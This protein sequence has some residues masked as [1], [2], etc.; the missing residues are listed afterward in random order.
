MEGG[1]AAVQTSLGNTKLKEARKYHV[2]Q[3]WTVQ[4]WT[5]PQRRSTGAGGI[6]AKT[7]QKQKLAVCMW[8][9]K[10]IW[11]FLWGDK[12]VLKLIMVATVH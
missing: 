4:E 2:L 7:K 12:N 3:T 9:C 11:G 1:V 5:S 8:A 6:L 10:W